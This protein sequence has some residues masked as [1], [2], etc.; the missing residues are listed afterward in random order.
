MSGTD[1]ASLVLCAGSIFVERT[2]RPQDGRT[3]TP[4][5]PIPN[6]GRVIKPG[7]FGDLDHICLRFKNFFGGLFWSLRLPWSSLRD[8]T[9]G[10]WEKAHFQRVAGGL[11]PIRA[12]FP[13]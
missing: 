6:S 12:G 7:G 5:I 1:A 3:R 4:H 8:F 11:Q 2:V 13:I 10:V 9:E